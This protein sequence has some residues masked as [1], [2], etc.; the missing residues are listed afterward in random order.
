MHPV[1]GGDAFG[2]P[3]DRGAVLYNVLISVE[4]REGDLMARRNLLTRDDRASVDLDPI[5]GGNQPQRD[6]DVVAL[7]DANRREAGR[8]RQRRALDRRAVRHNRYVSS[9]RS[10]ASARAIAR[11]SSMSIR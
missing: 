8:W 5:A 4:R 10:W 11:A 9:A 3:T 6:R 1:P 2:R 7:V